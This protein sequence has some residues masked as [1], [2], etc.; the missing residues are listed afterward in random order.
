VLVTGHR[1]ESFGGGIERLCTAVRD[2]AYLHDDVEIVYPVHLNPV[3]REEVGRAL[4]A[5]PHVHLVDPLDYVTFVA[6]MRRAH[7][8]ITD[9]GGIQEEAPWLNKP[10]I[11]T[12]EVTERP[13]VISAGAGVL[14]G[15]DHDGI[16]AAAN[17]LLTDE[18]EY[19]RMAS[20]ESPYGDGFA[21]ERIVGHLTAQLPIAG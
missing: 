10:V 12:R 13:E 3:V 7:L 2:L 17:R 9:S 5:V 14:V 8:I 20:A 16:V 4:P 6:L 15:T 21:A 11:I 18:D 1:R 19:A